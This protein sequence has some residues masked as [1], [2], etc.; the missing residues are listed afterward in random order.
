[1]F[2]SIVAK[3]LEGFNVYPRSKPFLKTGPNVI[4]PGPLPQGFLGGGLPGINPG[5]QQQILVKT[6]KNKPKRRST[7]RNRPL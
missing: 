2:D 5:Q 6:K 1:M 7:K 4:G 3:I